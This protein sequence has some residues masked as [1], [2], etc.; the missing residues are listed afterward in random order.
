MRVSTPISIMASVAIGRTMKATAWP[1]FSRE[2]HIADHRQ[3]FQLQAE[4]QQQQQAEP[5]ARDRQ[6]QRRAGDDGKVER[7][8]S[9]A[10][11]RS[12]RPAPRRRR[13]ARPRPARSMRADLEALEDQRQHGE[14]VGDR[15][16]E[17]AGRDLAE[18][19]ARTAPGSAGRA[20][21]AAR[22]CSTC[23]GSRAVAQHH[24][25]RIAGDQAHQREHRDRDQ[26]QGRDGH[27]KPSGE[28][29]QHRHRPMRLRHC[30]LT[31]Q[32]RGCG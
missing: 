24:L 21:A 4:Q 12:A 15:V 30:R 19:V 8:C 25:H 27:R 23:A 9:A 18:P 7:R 16:A 29:T 3:P 17:I 28:I 6:Q 32:K 14:P 13:R 10:T 2:R 1:K 26:Q 22:S 5:E 11:R 31:P 20:R